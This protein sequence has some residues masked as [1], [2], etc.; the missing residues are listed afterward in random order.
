M[1]AA[2]TSAVHCHFFITD[3]S[4]WPSSGK[5]GIAFF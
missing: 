1:R 5:F 3:F 2:N 4:V